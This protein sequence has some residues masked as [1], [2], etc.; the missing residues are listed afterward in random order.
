MQKLIKPLGIALL[1]TGLALVALVAASV[2][3]VS[4]DEHY[5]QQQQVGR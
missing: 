2:V 3:I 4:L 1:V 5:Q